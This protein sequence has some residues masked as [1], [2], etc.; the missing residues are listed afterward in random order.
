V[1]KGISF[2]AYYDEI[3]AIL[4]HNGAGK[5]TLINIM[6]GILSANKGEILYDG[7]PLQGNET[8]I[9]KKFG[10]CPQFDTFNNYL[11][12]SEH[13]KLFA[14]IK[15]IKVNVN[16][17][18]KDINLLK[19]KNCFPNKLSG[20]QKRKLCITLALLGSPK[21]IFLDE[22][23]TGLDP[24]S[25]KSIWDLLSKKKKDKIMFIT[26]H[27]MDEADV[28]ADRKMITS[29]GIITCLGTSLFLKNSFNMN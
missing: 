6:T 8:E 1:L 29:N 26:T 23:T 16:E 15:N 28:L 3:F 21:Y 14:G 5:T 17:I 4:G 11:T 19:K 9:C 20:G 13:V 24:Y 2:N 22:P 10:Y 18:L 25:R 27:Y 12:V 7:I